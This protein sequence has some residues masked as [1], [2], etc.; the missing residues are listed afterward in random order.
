MIESNFMF[1]NIKL[2]VKKNLLHIKLRYISKIIWRIFF[3]NLDSKISFKV[4]SKENI[5]RLTHVILII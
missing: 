2:R 4:E 5:Y 3:F 1:I